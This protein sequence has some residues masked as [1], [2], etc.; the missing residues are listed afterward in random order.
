[1]ERRPLIIGV[2]GGSGSGKTTVTRAIYE[3]PGVD[4]AFIDQDAYYRDL[5]HLTLEERKRVN[6][7]HP[8]AFDTDLLVRHLGQLQSGQ[9]IDKPTYD[10]AAHTRA[11]ATERVEPQRVILVDGIL[12]FADARL[13]PLFDIKIYVDVSE[14]VR[15][16]RRLQRDTAERGRSM[17]DVIRQYLA[18]VRPMHLEF[19]EP[20]KR[21]AD[22]IIPE[23]VENRVGVD[24]LRTKVHA[25]VTERETRR[26]ASAMTT[27]SSHG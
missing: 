13:R 23:G 20:S 22:I 1:V 10:Y 7:D 5:A 24:L 11:A 12:L 6:F 9:G 18:T 3:M 19:I 15:F 4:A 21:Y 17:D 2:V 25:I 16:I 14:D 8:E 27:R 26:V